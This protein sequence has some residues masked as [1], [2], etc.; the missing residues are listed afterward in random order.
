MKIEAKYMGLTLQS[1]VVVGACDL[2]LNPQVLKQMEEYG[3]GAIVFK[4]IFE[5]S[6]QLESMQ[7]KNLLESEQDRV[8]KMEKWYSKIMT[9]GNDQILK[10]LRAARSAVSIPLIASLNA[11][12]EESWIHYVKVLE[13][14][15]IDG[16]EI[17]FYHTPEGMDISGQEMEDREVGIIK[18]I[19]ETTDLPIS[20]K[21]TRC[22]TNPLYTVKRFMEAGAKGVILFN[23]FIDSDIDIDTEANLETFEL[24]QEG[25]YRES[26][27]FAALLYGRVEGSI[28]ANTGIYEAE[29]VI[30]LLLA[31]ADAVQ[32]VSTLYMN[33]TCQIERMIKGITDWMDQKG[34][35]SLDD[36]RGNCSKKDAVDPF[37]YE[38]AQYVK[39][40]LEDK[41]I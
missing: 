41:N 21:M 4:S 11:Y 36:F 33:Q 16:F 10:D 23:Q 22:Y 35:E 6:I 13:G 26:L 14:Y 3:A 17:N 37:A 38:R 2:S 7:L 32:V 24:T 12:S 8:K 25:A 28:I 18:K 19:V 15:G 27:R 29:D 34:Y 9:V 30:K 39:I 31:G 5:E 20:V 1:P 40:M